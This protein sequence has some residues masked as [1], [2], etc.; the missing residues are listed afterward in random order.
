MSSH[1]MEERHN[2]GGTEVHV[3]Q[4]S[5]AVFSFRSHLLPLNIGDGCHDEKPLMGGVI[6]L[7]FCWISLFAQDLS[8]QTL[9]NK[10]RIHCL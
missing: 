6:T 10:P 1:R 8:D 3:I 9:V 2:R 4:Q 5:L 7:L